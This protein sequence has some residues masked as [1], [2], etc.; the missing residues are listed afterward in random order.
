MHKSILQLVCCFALALAPITITA[1]DAAMKG[2]VPPI[3]SR[4]LILVTT[5]D[6]DAV[7]GSLQRFERRSAKAWW[8]P[9]G[10]AIPVVVGRNG[11]GWG[12]GLSAP[13]GDGPVKKE[14]D[15]KAPAGIFKLGPAFGYASEADAAWLRMPYTPLAETVECVDDVSSRR[16]NLIVDRSSVKDVDW[17]SSE[18]MRSVGV[19]RWGVVV[20]H[21]SAPPIAGKGSCIFLHIWQAADKG[22]AGCTAMEQNALEELMRWLDAKKRPVLAQLP[23]AEYARMRGAWRLTPAKR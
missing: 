10:A 16:Y 5:R 20:E 2:G 21:N 4:Q 6:W 19:Y 12:V 22:T 8:K 1:K 23:E 13:S 9:V 3:K 15:G 11:L 17:N 18:R 14:G 7:Q